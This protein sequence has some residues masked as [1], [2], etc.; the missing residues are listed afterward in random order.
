M[1]FNNTV[2]DS[3]ERG[4]HSDWEYMCGFFP[5]T[6]TLDPNSP[7]PGTLARNKNNLWPRGDTAYWKFTNAVARDYTLRT[8]SP[9]IDQ[10]VVIPGWVTTYQGAAPDLGAYESGEARWIPGAD[11]QDQA[12]QYPPPPPNSTGRGTWGAAA[13]L[14]T[15]TLRML[16]GRMSIGIPAGMNGRVSVYDAAGALVASQSHPNGATAIV[17]TG[18]FAPGM[19]L[20]RLTSSANSVTWKTIIR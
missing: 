9:A 10:G 16:P 19:Y 3:V 4:N 14:H 5:G 8:G 11:W 18:S 7:W 1:C 20:V 2:V 17:E 12:W 13:R 15:A 6:Q